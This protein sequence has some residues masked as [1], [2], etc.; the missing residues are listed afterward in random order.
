MQASTDSASE[1]LDH[2]EDI[3][4]CF[5]GDSVEAIYSALQRRG[6][7]WAD[8]TLAALR[9]CA[10]ARS[11]HAQHRLCW[12]CLQKRWTMTTNGSA[13]YETLQLLSPAAEHSCRPAI[14]VG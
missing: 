5:A 8:A 12:S 10:A 6:G 4:T 11:P 1:V 7:S 9:K 13:C 2:R 14:V 3:D